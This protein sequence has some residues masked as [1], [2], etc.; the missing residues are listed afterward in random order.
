MQKK[1]ILITKDALRK[2]YLPVYGNKFWKTPNIDEL[3]SK[4]TMFNNHYTAGTSTAMSVT[5]MFTGKNSYE[6]DRKKYVEVDEYKD[7]DTLFSELH[8]KEYK[9]FVIWPFEW[10]ELAWKYS[11]VFPKETTV[12]S[13][14]GISEN[15]RRD[16]NRKLVDNQ[17]DSEDSLKLI[18]NKIDNIIGTNNDKIFVWVHFPHVI[19]GRCSYG[20]DI[21]LFDDFIGG[22]RDRFDDNSIYISS[23]HG[24]MNFEKNIAVYGFHVYQGTVAIPLITPRLS[25]DLSVVN[26]TTSNI[27]L[28]DIILRN[29]VEKPRYVY[30]DTQY[31]MQENRK[32][33]II[34]DEYKYIYNKINK[35]E[36]L[37]DLRFDPNENVNLLITKWYDR[38]RLGY[39]NLQ[40]IYF[41]PFWENIDEIYKELKNEKDRVWKEGK[42]YYETLYKLNNYR[43]KGFSNFSNIINSRRKMLGN[44]G[45]LIK[46]SFFEK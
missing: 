36:E 32:L 40:D 39:Y 13:L 24:N 23:D 3:A 14:K 21:D 29:S 33:A 42:W 38:N 17:T 46:N 7:G 15:I 25:D 28:K 37:Y 35:T 6:L 30:S 5:S 12:I 45:A 31:Y 9:T 43:K 44:F 18:Y 16:S 22:I 20:G 8:L 26:H 1:M 19:K 27:Q 41:Y 34:K 2:D 11:K 10:K 4:G